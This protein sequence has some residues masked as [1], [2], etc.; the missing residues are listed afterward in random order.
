M[1]NFVGFAGLMIAIAIVLVFASAMRAVALRVDAIRVVATD[2]VALNVIAVPNA[3]S[4]NSGLLGFQLSFP[5][6]AEGG[7]P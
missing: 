1:R 5:V 6:S 7:A 3:K 2:V 4:R